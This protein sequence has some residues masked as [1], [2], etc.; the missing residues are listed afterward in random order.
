MRLLVTGGAGYIGGFTTRLLAN[1]GH[2]VTVLDTL[3]AGDERAVG[4]AELVVGDICDRAAVAALLRE[5]GV[6]AVL[7]FAALK[8]VRA[9]WHEPDRYR[10]VNVSGTR[11]LLDAMADAGVGVLV[12]SGTCAVYGTPRHLPVDETAPVAPLNPYGATKLQAERLVQMGGERQSLRYCSLRYFNAAGASADG[13]YGEEPEAAVSLVPMAIKA[14]LGQIPFLSVFGTDY[15]TPDGTAIRDYVH[16]EDLARAHAQALDY[17]ADGG[18]SEVLNLGTGQGMS[19]RQV[20]SMTEQVAGRSIPVRLERRR[21]GDPAAIWADSSRA[22]RVLGWRAGLGIEEIVTSA[23][24]WQ[25]GRADRAPAAS[26]Q[27]SAGSSR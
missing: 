18:A 24:R 14:A 11:A 6:Q 9:S 27:Q 1:A 4:G 22:N 12:Y 26:A 8:S 25:S 20:I 23:W 10:A 7:H 21:D 2:E 3:E 15:P 5:R 16:V 19:V 13:R 17:L